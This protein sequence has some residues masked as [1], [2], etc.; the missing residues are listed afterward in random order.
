MF[1]DCQR[2]RLYKTKIR[3]AYMQ[4]IFSRE[5]EMST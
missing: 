5:K 2:S 3:K 1:E 4:K